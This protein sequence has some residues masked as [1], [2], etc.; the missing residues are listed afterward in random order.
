[1]PAE[2]GQGSI[3]ADVSAILSRYDQSR[4]PPLLDDAADQIVREDGSVPPDPAQAAAAGHERLTLWL[5]VFSRFKRDLDPQFDPDK[6]PP[7]RVLPPKIDGMQLMPGVSPSQI[8]DP[9]LRKK[10]E[11]DIAHNQERLEQFAI[12]LKLHEAHQSLLERAVE[13]LK[14]ARETLG[15]KPQDIE[16]ALA[17]A[18]ITPADREALRAGIL[19]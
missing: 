3:K 13:S 7:N 12:Q 17:K 1:M 2:N 11:Y 10:Y 19:H 9:E 16:A 6:P 18:D 8:P 4:D 14:D 15:L 5:D